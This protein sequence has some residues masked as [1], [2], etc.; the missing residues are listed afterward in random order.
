MDERQVEP[1]R[2]VGRVGFHGF[3]EL[4]AGA[5]GP[6]RLHP[7]D[8]Q[9]AARRGQGAPGRGVVRSAVRRVL[10]KRERLLRLILLDQEPAEVRVGGELARV[11]V[12]RRAEQL[13][14]AGRVALGKRQAGEVVVELETRV[15]FRESRLEEDA[16]LRPLAAL[17]HGG[18]ELGVVA[19]RRGRHPPAR[20]RK[21]RPVPCGGVGE[22]GVGRRRAAVDLHDGAGLIQQKARRQREVLAPVEEVAVENRVRGHRVIVGGDHGEREHERG[23]LRPRFRTVDR[24][25]QD[26]HPGRLE[27]RRVARQVRELRPAGGTPGRPEVHQ[28]AAPAQVRA[29]DG[30]RRDRVDEPRARRRPQLGDRLGLEGSA[31]GLDAGLG[32]PALADPERA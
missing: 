14:C 28:R 17:G 13:L 23:D 2:R 18:R 16:G 25:G 22:Q 6:A 15:A 7:P 27:P 30:R 11:G 3:Q 12:K 29:R 9:L 10:E 1:R 26:L 32:R 31:P 4:D 5:L 20:E 19:P 21:R 8:P 24:D